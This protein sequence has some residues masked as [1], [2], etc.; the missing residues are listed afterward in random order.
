MSELKP[1]PFCGTKDPII[2]RKARRQSVYGQPIHGT[3][4]GCRCCE[5]TMF[6]RSEKLAIK[7]WNRRAD[8]ESN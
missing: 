3:R 8:D 6:Y 2:V 4:I 1:C 5:A 7:A